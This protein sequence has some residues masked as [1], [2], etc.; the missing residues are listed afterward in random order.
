M[1]TPRPLGAQAVGGSLSNAS[2]SA[3]TAPASAAVAQAARQVDC[4]WL[5][6][7]YAVIPLSLLIVVTDML[8][9]ERAWLYSYFPSSPTHWAFWAVIF[10]LPHIVASLLTMADREYV[11][12]YRRSLGWPLLF[13]AFVSVLGIAGPQPLSYRLLFGVVAVY[14]AYHVLAQQ[15][16]LTLMMMNTAPSRAFKAWKWIALASGVAL[17]LSIFHELG[18]GQVWLGS[19]LGPIYL[20]Q[21]LA[22]VAGALSAVLVF[23]G[24]YV[25]RQSRT[26]IGRWYMWANV[27]MLGS[28]VWVNE[29][30]Y[31]LFVIFIPRIIHDITAFSV[32]ITHDTNRNRGEPRNAVY[33]V[34]RFTRLPP[35]VLLPLLSIGIAYVLTINERYALAAI[36]ISTITFLHYYFE[37]FIWR[38]PNPH[39]QHCSFRK[40]W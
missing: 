19:W 27:A 4:R 5:L 13:F 25:H 29:L 20:D 21:F 12:H 31:T 40:E 30:G 32:Y 24:V 14:T 37:G 17:H 26:R 33:R 8:F 38:G 11:G 18:L 10:G 7:L 23:L 15:L 3:W 9:L 16:G 34:A 22:Y 6:A 28:I 35:L 36:V 39:R 1:S 2:S